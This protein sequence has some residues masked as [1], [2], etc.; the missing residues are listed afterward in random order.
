MAPKIWLGVENMKILVIHGSMRKGTTYALTQ[1]ITSRLAAMP[2][3]EITQLHVADLDL[4][5]CRSCHLCF[6]KGEEFCPHYGVMEEVAAKLTQCDGV[7]VSGVSYM[8]ALNASMKNFLDHLSF[9]F[10]RPSLFGKKGMVIA[11][12]AGAGEKSVAKYLKTVLGQWGINKALV[13]TQTARDL[14][15]ISTAKRAAKYDK[16]AAKFYSLIKSQRP[17]SPSLQNLAVH[18]AFRAM[19][20]SGFTGSER[21]TLYWQQ[22][23]FKNKA[24]PIKAGWFRSLAGAVIYSAVKA[25]SAAAGRMAAKNK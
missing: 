20:L 9:L 14:E 17:L 19:S 6:S 1:E 10:H 11:T 4:P 18:N 5:F 16:L 23:G 13:V 22:D 12:A 7:I 8:W 2:E 3:V 25:S 24:Y 15:M 21:D